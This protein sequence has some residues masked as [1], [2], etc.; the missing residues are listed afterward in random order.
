MTLDTVLA[1][2]VVATLLIVS[3][4]PNNLLIARTVPTSGR[5]AGFATIAGFVTAFFLHGTLAVFGLSV[6]L[7]SSATAFFIVKMLG[8]A[9]LCWVGIKALVEAWRGVATIRVAPARRPRSLRR[10]YVEGLLTNA[11]NPKVSMFYIA[12]LPQFLPPEAMTPAN[13]YALVL[14]HSALNATW[15]TLMVML[16]SRLTGVVTSGRVQ[17]WVKGATGLVFL[18]FGVKLISLK[19]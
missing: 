14:V 6:L 10:A 16:F 15:F 13:V 11:L 12:A 5:A 2:A 19:P 1:F 8:A 17:A 18:G 3:P 4:G 9:Y 7:L